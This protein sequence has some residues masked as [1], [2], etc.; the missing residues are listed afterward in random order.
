MTV[1]ND[2]ELARERDHYRRR[3]AEHH[4]RADWNQHIAA[5]AMREGLVECERLR[6]ALDDASRLTRVILDIDEFLRAENKRISD[7]ALTMRDRAQEAEESLA[8]IRGALRTNMDSTWPLVEVLRRLAVASDH[9][10]DVHNCDDE[11]NE[12]VR[13]AARSAREI[14]T[15]LERLGE[16]L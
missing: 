1:A 7:G 11:G 10:L 14:V 4:A 8:T 9:L 13:F 12:E 6:K 5:E 15:A 3:A 16:P 2:S